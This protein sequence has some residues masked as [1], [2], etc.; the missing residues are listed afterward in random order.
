MNKMV[1]NIVLMIEETFL[2]TLDGEVI[3]GNSHLFPKNPKYPIHLCNG[4]MFCQLRSNDLVLGVLYM[5]IDDFKAA[6][7]LYD[8][9]LFL[10]S[11]V[12]ELTDKNV[13]KN[14]VLFLECIMNFRG[15]LLPDNVFSGDLVK[16]LSIYI[17][18]VET[19]YTNIDKTG[20]LLRNITLGNVL[21]S[22][23]QFKSILVRIKKSS[24]RKVIFR[25]SYDMM[26]DL[27]SL[28]VQAENVSRNQPLLSYTTDNGEIPLISLRKE[29]NKFT[30]YTRE[31][32]SIKHLKFTIPVAENTFHAETSTTA[33][34]AV[35]NS[36][37]K[38]VEWEIN[39]Q[40][41]RRETVIINGLTYD[42]RT[43]CSRPIIL[44]FICHMEK[45][46]NMAIESCK[47]LDIPSRN[48]FA[49]FIYQHGY[50]EIDQ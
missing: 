45:S 16:A 18:V 40:S 47:C 39:N 37:K 49:R 22:G 19:F 32:L 33:G 6:K 26:D 30:F 44:E 43:S 29:G 8:L 7:Y 10:K 11:Q 1:L 31:E 41:F 36:D 15:Q 28:E 48:V 5:A 46:T 20:V 25:S 4:K 34:D 14:Y 2:S 12:G 3:I 21:V 50:Y 35:F 17:D 23:R 24:D 38:Q 27:N 9:K 13:R 42:N